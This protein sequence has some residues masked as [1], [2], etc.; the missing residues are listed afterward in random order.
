MRGERQ[1]H[2]IDEKLV[3]FGRST[4]P[5]QQQRSDMTH[6]LVIMSDAELAGEVANRRRPGFLG[7]A[8]ERR[9][10]QI[11][12]ERMKRLVDD[13]TRIAP[14]IIQICRTRFDIRLPDALAVIPELAVWV[15]VKLQ[16]DEIGLI[17]H[18]AGTTRYRIINLGFGDREFD[19]AQ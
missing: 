15:I 14:E 9:T 3:G 2:V 1:H 4:E 10:R 16:A 8:V 11:E 12:V 13:E 17:G 19:A 18:G 7:D 5:L 6:D